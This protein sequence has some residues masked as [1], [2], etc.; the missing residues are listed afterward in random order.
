VARTA[1]PL[2]PSTLTLRLMMDKHT[3]WKWLF[4][5]LLL[6][7]S[8]A[9]VWPPQEKVPLG[10]DLKGGISFVVQVQ[11]DELN[12]EARQDAPERALEVIRN[13]ID[14]IGTREPIIYLEPRQD[15]IVVQLPGIAAEDRDQM[16]ELL[17][18]A[19]YLE[20]RM[21]HEDNDQ[22]VNELFAERVEPPGYRLVTLDETGLDGRVVQNTYYKR[23]ADPDDALS[24]ERIE[25]G[26]DRLNR[27]GYEFMLMPVNR[28]GHELYQPYYVGRRA[29]LTGELLESAGVDYQQ[30]GQPV[31][32][33]QFDSEGARRF[34]RL[35]ADYAPG[36]A[37]NPNP[38]GQ[39][40]L[41]IVLDGTLY[42]APFIRTAI[43]GGNA[44]IEGDFTPSEAQ[45]LATVLRAGSL[46]APVKVVQERVVDPTLGRDSIRSGGRALIYGACAVVVFV[47]LYYF[48]AGLVANISLALDFLLLPLGMVVVSGFLGLLT[49]TGP[50]ASAISLPT[51]TLPG[52]AGIV[53]TIGM[54]VDANVL[55]FERIREEQQVGKRFKSAIAAGYEKAFSTIFDANITTLITAVI[56]FWQGSGPIR[57]FAVTLS[58]G[59][60][61]SMYVALVV[62]RM[63]FNALADRAGIE[64]LK[65]MQLVRN[66][67]FD[68]V[69]K[70]LMTGV[71][72]LLLIVGAWAVF[73][74]KGEQ[75]FG[76]DFTGGRVIAFQFSERQPVAEIRE[77]LAGAGIQ[78]ALIQYQRE[79]A[80]DDTGTRDEYL[81]IKVGFDEGELAKSALVEAFSESRFDVVKEDSV[82]PQIGA[83]LRRKG[84]WAV[85]AAMIGIVL[86]I[87]FRFE[88][89]FAVGAITA[90]A[91][92][93]LVTVGLYCL[94]G[95][96]LSLPIIA[97]LLTIVGYSVNDTIVVFDRIREDLQLIK[98]KSYKEIAN[99]SINQT[100][101]RT[102]LTSVTTL[103]TV[104][105]LLIFGGGAINDFA[106]A[107][108]IGILVGTYSS[109]FVA[110]PIVLLWH[111]ER[112]A[113]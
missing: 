20:F 54:A 33:L 87:S 90:V 41:A 84:V 70:R 10:I 107:L 99:L 23:I 72:S 97:A 43:Y 38:D 52:I 91:H 12:E 65:M 28:R 1:Q 22:M 76:V 32:T 21:V 46:P 9:M 47:L 92:D 69:G 110:T 88:F 111:R 16:V 34:A 98:D 85:I 30:F 95:R 104:A 24:P 113:P 6:A 86:Y 39:R 96:Q 60:V 77:A 81:E 19:A 2:N 45:Q 57:G 58:A 63:I 13:R 101:S 73:I 40:F 44:I 93:V 83:E 18:S 25:A 55:I 15:R 100:L 64:S 66:P 11:T 103:L 75:N 4:L 49:T 80:P 102:L 71:L 106:L 17:E 42:S 31:V 29:Q 26:L 61:V 105:M 108:F 36:G 59:I 94:F 5:V 7:V 68:F 74:A 56:L 27:G 112:R 67:A 3:L 51:L 14:A 78:D 53:L 109:V 37:K 82:G 35:T 79:I 62:T 48:L 89:A 50:S 8:L